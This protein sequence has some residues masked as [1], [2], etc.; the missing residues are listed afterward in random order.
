MESGENSGNNG[1][2]N[3]RE[4]VVH[5]EIGA[6]EAGQ[7]IDNFLLTRLKGVPRSRIYRLLRKGEVRVNGKRAK[8]T[9]RIEEG[10]RVRIPPV[11]TAVR[12]PVR[13]P[14]GALEQIRAAVIHEEADLLVLDKPPG[15]AVHAGSETPWGVIEALRAAR[16]DE[17]FL[18][19]AHRLDR[20]TSGC[21]LFARSRSALLALQAA[22]SDPETTK[23]YLGL[24]RGPWPD[25]VRVVDAPLR[26]NVL[27]G[28]ERMVQVDPN[29]KAAVTRFK[30]LELMKGYALMEASLE[31]GRTHQIRVHAA[32][33]GSPVAGDE[34]YGDPEFNRRLRRLGLRRLF[35]HAQSLSLRMGDRQ[36]DVETPLPEDLRQVLQAVQPGRG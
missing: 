6:A 36:L 27:Q 13:V 2:N 16:P 29:G 20:G 33:V 11:R 9:Q 31:T 28:G 5:V 4:R 17:P 25:G 19:L 12:G 10:D 30:V 21:L 1:P 23:R 34:R 22:L 32:S 26:R 3:G 8:P 15:M 14:D 24:V 18:E 35:L 7:R